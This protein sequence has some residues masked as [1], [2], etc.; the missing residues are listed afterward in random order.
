M[1][2]LCDKVQK[3][4]EGCTLDLHWCVL[5][6]KYDAV[7]VVIYIRRILEEPVT[8]VDRYRN[9]TMIL[10]CRMVHTS[11]ISLIFA[12]K[13]AFWI[14][15]CLGILG[16]CDRLWILLRLGKIDRDI[17]CSELCIGCP[18]TILLDTCAADIIAVTA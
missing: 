14:A 7:L 10:S 8:I 11:C 13:L 16:C 18:L 9:N 12:A 5:S 4:S 3:L 2:E 6:V 17:K 1:R 15:A